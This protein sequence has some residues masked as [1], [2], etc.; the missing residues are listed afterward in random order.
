ML[1]YTHIDI[2]IQIQQTA[3]MNAKE[4]LKEKARKGPIIL[5]T[6][7]KL[8]SNVFS[9]FNV[10][11]LNV[12]RNECEQFGISRWDT[13]D[14]VTQMCFQLDLIPFYFI[15]WNEPL[16]IHLTHT[17]ADILSIY[18]LTIRYVSIINRCCC[19]LFHWHANMHSLPLSSVFSPFFAHFVNLKL[20][21]QIKLNLIERSNTVW[22]CMCV[23]QPQSN[24]I[25]FAWVWV[26]YRSNRFI[27]KRLG[28]SS[29]C[30][31]S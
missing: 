18:H 28:V 15:V 7:F 25:W 2:R 30:C 4:E 9:V 8:K 19:F 12:P 17:H 26:F 5:R 14:V 11:L 27:V 6:A 22:V 3:T 16:T 1:L 21:I 13:V 23:F 24:P 10:N 20:M 29:G 31:H